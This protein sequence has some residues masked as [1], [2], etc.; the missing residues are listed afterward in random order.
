MKQILTCTT[1]NENQKNYAVIAVLH[2]KVTMRPSTWSKHSRFI[3][4]SRQPL[5]LVQL[6]SILDVNKSTTV[7]W[8]TEKRGKYQWITDLKNLKN[9]VKLCPSISFC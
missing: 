8:S 9:T 7:A 4:C 2:L 1:Q 3:V 5:E 6:N